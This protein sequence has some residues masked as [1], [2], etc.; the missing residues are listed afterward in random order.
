MHDWKIVD[1][2]AERCTNPSREVITRALDRSDSD[3]VQF[4]SSVFLKSM[5]LNKEFLVCYLSCRAISYFWA[6]F[7]FISRTF[8]KNNSVYF[9]CCPKPLLKFF[10]CAPR[11]A[12]FNADGPNFGCNLDKPIPKVHS[13]AK[14]CHEQS[15]FD[16][17]FYWPM[18]NG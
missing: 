9:L 3:V 7:I 8:S 10:L 12:N 2:Q 15:Q 18:E 17:R 16:T 4:N 5:P 1:H 11:N 6:R 14:G 13:Y